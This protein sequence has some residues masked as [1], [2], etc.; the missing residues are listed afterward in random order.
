MRKAVYILAIAL[1]A[2]MLSSIGYAYGKG[3]NGMLGKQARSAE[4]GSGVC[5]TKASCPTS[6][7]C[8]EGDAGVNCP[9]QGGSQGACGE[10]ECSQ[11]GKQGGGRGM[12]AQSPEGCPG[13]VGCATN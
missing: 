2:L 13:G 12:R 6:E 11:Q 7:N 9:Q 3:P 5:D 1:V 4:C 8:P 10:G